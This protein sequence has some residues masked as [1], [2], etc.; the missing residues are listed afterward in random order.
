LPSSYSK[1]S[2]P[3]AV[4]RRG[5]PL[6]CPQE[7]TLSSFFPS[8]FEACITFRSVL[9]SYGQELF[10]PNPIHI[11]QNRPLSAIPNCI[12]H[13]FS[14]SLHIAELCPPTPTS[15]LAMPSGRGFT[16]CIRWN[17]IKCTNRKRR[18]YSERKYKCL[19][20]VLFAVL[21]TS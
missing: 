16:S 7:T 15:G 12:L 8:N 10:T 14:V 18:G 5:K 21:H 13:V 17:F 1:N 2:L 20:N 4:Y 11:L 3:T 19:I 9:Y 6:L